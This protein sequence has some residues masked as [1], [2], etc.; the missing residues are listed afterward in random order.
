MNG[1]RRSPE[2]GEA[3]EVKRRAREVQLLINL[4][5]PDPSYQPM[6]VSDMASVFDVSDETE[7]Q[8]RRKIEFYLGTTLTVP[9]NQ[10]LWK[11]ID[12]LKATIPG[13]PDQVHQ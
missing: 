11:L 2:F 10:P 5:V 12:G 3:K 13:W 4:L 8:I 9:L 6:F 7:E 1:A